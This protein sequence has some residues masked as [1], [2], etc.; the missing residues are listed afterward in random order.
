MNTQK[1]AKSRILPFRCS[2]CTVDVKMIKILQDS[3]SRFPKLLRQRKLFRAIYWFKIAQCHT[4]HQLPR[5][6]LASGLVS[7]APVIKMAG[8]L[9]RWKEDIEY[10]GLRFFLLQSCVAGMVS[11]KLSISHVIWYWRGQILPLRYNQLL[12]SVLNHGVQKENW[13]SHIKTA[14]GSFTKGAF[15]NVLIR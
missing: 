10:F 13:I 1:N 8:N 6:H 15:C 12:I 2:L 4:T 5:I 7:W 11:I 9:C 3:A 14:F